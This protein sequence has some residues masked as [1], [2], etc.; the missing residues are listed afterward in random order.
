MDS[1]DIDL[2]LLEVWSD[3]RLR[4]FGSSINLDHKLLS[5]K[6]VLLLGEVGSH[7]TTSIVIK[8][9]YLKTLFPFVFLR[10]IKRRQ[11]PGQ[12]MCLDLK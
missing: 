8:F 3:T 7:A 10:K 4:Y 6:L 12:N 11:Y 9:S 1:T 5:K 2:C